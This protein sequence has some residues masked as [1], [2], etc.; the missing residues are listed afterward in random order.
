MRV[1]II[2]VNQLRMST[3]N[4]YIN[5]NSQRF[6]LHSIHESLAITHKAA[7]PGNPRTLDAIRF[8][9]VRPIP[10]RLPLAHSSENAQNTL[11]AQRYSRLFG[12]EKAENIH[13]IS[14]SAA[15]NPVMIQWPV[16]MRIP[17]VNAM[18]DD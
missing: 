11:W 2:I 16:S 13:K 6:T 18:R 4:D 7:Y 12:A 3:I 1:E 9:P 15:V 17:P 8:T 5:L 10:P 14:S